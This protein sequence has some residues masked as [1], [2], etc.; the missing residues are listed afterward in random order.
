MKGNF[1]ITIETLDEAGQFPVKD[2]IIIQ[3]DNIPEGIGEMVDYFRKI[4][5]V[6]GFAEETIT[7]VLGDNYNG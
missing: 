6:M 5:F 7:E 2:T 1:R 3:R 4:L